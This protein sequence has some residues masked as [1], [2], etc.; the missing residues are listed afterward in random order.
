LALERVLVKRAATATEKDPEKAL[1]GALRELVLSLVARRIRRREHEVSTANR[2]ETLKRLLGVSMF[3]EMMELA[4]EI[5]TIRLQRASLG[6]TS[7]KCLAENVGFRSLPSVIPSPVKQLFFHNNL[8]RILHDA[9]LKALPDLDLKSLVDSA[10]RDLLEYKEWSKGHNS[11]LRSGVDC[12][13]S[14]RR[15]VHRVSSFS[16]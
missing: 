3:E 6:C 11:D 14:K 16:S 12:G 1:D 4:R 9:P 5:E 7:G 13:P 15:C 2:T 10:K 8:S